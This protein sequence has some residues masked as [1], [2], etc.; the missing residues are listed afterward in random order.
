MAF[1][2]RKYNYHHQLLPFVNPWGP[3][4]AKVPGFSYEDPPPPP[5]HTHT[6]SEILSPKNLFFAVIT[7]KIKCNA[8]TLGFI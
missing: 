5:P 7:T 6:L 2:A 4:R 1:I 8:Q 3:V